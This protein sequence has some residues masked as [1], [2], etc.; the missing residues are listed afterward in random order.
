V[1][2]AGSRLRRGVDTIG[3]VANLAVAIVALCVAGLLIGVLG[4]VAG[5][6]NDMGAMMAALAGPFAGGTLVAIVGIVVAWHGRR[7]ASLLCAG[8]AIV[9]SIAPYGVYAISIR[10]AEQQGADDQAASQRPK[11]ASAIGRRCNPDAGQYFQGDC[12]DQYQ[13][14]PGGFTFD[15]P[16][17]PTCEVRC[18]NNDKYCPTGTRCLRG[19]CRTH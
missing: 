1:Q 16:P 8:G 19:W 15:G 4:L 13:C 6:S 11:D 18:P 9:A 17:E 14:I 2:P 3:V 10:S 7:L 12:P 5:S